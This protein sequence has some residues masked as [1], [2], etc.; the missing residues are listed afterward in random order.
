MK[1]LKLDKNKK[2]L[3]AC[4]YG[5]DSMALFHM[6]KNSGYNFEC[7]I[8]NY[9]IREESTSEV[10]GLK[11]YASAFGVQVYVHE[12]TDSPL[13][14]TEAKCREIRYNFFSKLYKEYGFDALLVAHHQDDLIETYLMQKR[15]QNCPIYFGIKQ[16]SV[17]KGMNVV[18]PLLDYSKRELQDY[19][20]KNHVPYAI[21]KTNFDVSILRNKIRHEIVE[22]MSEKDRT[23]ILKEIENRNRDL[24]KLISSIDLVKIHSANYLASLDDLTLKYALNIMVKRIKESYYLSKENVGEIKKAI[25]SKKPNINFEIKRGLYFLKEYDEVDI[26]R[27]TQFSFNYSYILDRPGILDTPFFRLDFTNGARNRNVSDSD[28]PIVIRAAKLDDYIFINGYKAYARRL[29]IDW[30]MP[31]KLRGRWPIILNKNNEPLYIPRYQKDFV[32][33][34]E[35]NFIVKF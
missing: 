1:E 5:P 2:Y 8:V 11:E 25:L 9:H 21:D 34:K 29:F 31:M 15:R 4:S 17:I 13:G 12:C 33:N 7:A 19:C 27:A 30:K 14:K 3:L 24:D 10:E 35:N 18:R 16:K 23:D 26:D 6:L 32:L 20:D 22:L 28:Y